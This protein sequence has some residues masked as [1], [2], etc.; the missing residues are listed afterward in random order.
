V[1]PRHGPRLTALFHRDEYPSLPILADLVGKRPYLQHGTVVRQ[2][3]S[4]AEHT[5]P[6]TAHFEL[7][8]S[9]HRAIGMLAAAVMA[10]MSVP[11]RRRGRGRP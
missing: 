3:G 11:G 2:N 7:D 10:M 8:Q 6:G 5:G 1:C 4:P 9:A